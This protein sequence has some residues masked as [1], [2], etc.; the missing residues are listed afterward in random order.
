[1]SILA[2][3]GKIHPWSVFTKGIRQRIEMIRVRR[4]ERKV[5]WNWDTSA[6]MERWWVG[7]AGREELDED[8]RSK[9]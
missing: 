4:L 9:K 6:I 3:L 7:V 1:M 8:N 5:E 2:Y